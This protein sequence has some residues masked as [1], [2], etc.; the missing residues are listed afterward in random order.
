MYLTG[1]M[2]Y[3]AVACPNIQELHLGVKN[4]ESHYS[5]FSQARDFFTGINFEH[6]QVLTINGMY[7]FNGSYLSLVMVT[8]SFDQ[9]IESLI[10]FSLYRS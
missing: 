2:N 7:L 9:I 8:L 1:F 6:L 3:V 5:L 10:V 4:G